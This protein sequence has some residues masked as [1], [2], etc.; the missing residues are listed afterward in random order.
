MT[1]ISS[2]ADSHR[3]DDIMTSSSSS[4]ASARHSPLGHDPEKQSLEKQ[5]SVDID[6]DDKFTVSMGR[7]VAS[8]SCDSGDGPFQ[9]VSSSA[10]IF[11]GSDNDRIRD[12]AADAS[13]DATGPTFAGGQYRTYR[14]RWFGLVEL[15]LLNAI[16]S[17]N[18]SCCFFFFFFRRSLPFF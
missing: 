18:V 13:G 11:S 2:S 16:G 17:W 6:A 8:S 7:V 1:A 12:G 14:R 9:T 3:A 5:A 4:Q 15:A 10:V